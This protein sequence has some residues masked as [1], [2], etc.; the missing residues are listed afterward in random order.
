VS[1]YRVRLGSYL[2]VGR[3]PQTTPFHPETLTRAI[4]SGLTKQSLAAAKGWIGNV[5]DIAKHRP[6]GIN[7]VGA[8]REFIPQTR[9]TG[10]RS[11]PSDWTDTDLEPLWSETGCDWDF[12]RKLY[13]TLFSLV[14]IER[15][16]DWG[17]WSDEG[18]G[19]LA[20]HSYVLWPAHM[21]A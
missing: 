10:Y 20:T 21:A 17:T 5:L 8:L 16:E 19:P 15:P 13:G 14:A 2:I 18:Y 7:S 1:L 9:K 6:Q 12:A 4:K 3:T 11:V